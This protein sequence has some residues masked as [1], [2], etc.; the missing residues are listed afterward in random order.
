MDPDAVLACVPGSGF[1]IRARARGVPGGV[2]EDVPSGL[3][4]D[5]AVA[6]MCFRHGASATVAE[7]CLRH[8]G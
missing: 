2:P 6:E 7:M 4:R 1:D 5:R 3:E 8:G